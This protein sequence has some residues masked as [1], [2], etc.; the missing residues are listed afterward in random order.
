MRALSLE[1]IEQFA[2]R[3]FLLAVFALPFERIGALETSLGTVRA[4]QVFVFLAFAAL[5]L[6][7]ETFRKLRALSVFAPLLVFF[8]VILL[9][10]PFSQNISRTATVVG[11]TFFTVLFGLSVPLFVNSEERM[12]RMIVL[13]LISA[14]L[15]SFFGLFQF[16]GDFGGLP[17][18]VTGLREHYTK[19]VFGFP[20][21]QSTALEPL[22]F[23]N[24]LLMPLAC[25]FSFFLS[26]R[27]AISWWFL[28]LVAL[29]LVNIVLTVSRGGYL[30]A[31][32]ALVVVSV[33]S[34]R[35]F[36]RLRV[37]VP[38]LLLG[39]VMLV[40]VPRFLQTGDVE[41]VN[42]G[43]FTEHVR[44]VFYGASYHERIE[45]FEAAL[46]AWRSAPWIGIGFGGF[47]PLV[48][49]HPL[50]EPEGGWRIVNNE[51]L[52]LLAETGIF[53]L[54]AFCF[55]LWCVLRDGLRALFAETTSAFRC[56]VGIGAF[57]AVLGILVQ[58]QT[59]STLAIM[60]VWFAFG[61][62]LAITRR[63]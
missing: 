18:S 3:C 9:G 63:P 23:A 62:L 60:H 40:L 13:V 29:F 33:F 37:I 25:A 12:K 45:T 36:L 28:G 54:L 6:L 26:R 7:P 56:A 47:G 31:M 41:R 51:F 59:F 21:I 22:Y 14:T 1:R 34:L 53:G 10:I 11:V 5:L 24:F 46:A 20:R 27:S 32:V 48:A 16:F 61:I 30:A 50:F 43:V 17:A 19:E 15:V 39:I 42:L 52:E 49:Q 8:A 58:Y 38:L 4:S 44:N 35:K 55:F 2:W 57:G